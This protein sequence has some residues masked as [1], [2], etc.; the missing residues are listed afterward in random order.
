MEPAGGRG[1][2]TMMRVGSPP[3]WES[4]TRSRSRLSNIVIFVIFEVL[5]Q[6][7]RLL[8]RAS[9]LHTLYTVL[10]MLNPLTLIAG[11]ALH[12][13]NMHVLKMEPSDPAGPY[14]LA[15]PWALRA[16]VRRRTRNGPAARGRK[17]APSAN[18]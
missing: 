13:R 15:V 11:A 10:F 8:T 3:V 1:P 18:P 9:N 5:R 2:P 4:T 17:R 14:Q 16:P 7:N 6:A 12:A